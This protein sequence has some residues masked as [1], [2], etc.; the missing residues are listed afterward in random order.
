[1]RLHT[2]FDPIGQAV[3]MFTGY[4]QT[5]KQSI[6]IKMEKLPTPLPSRNVRKFYH[7]FSKADCEDK[8]W[9]RRLGINSFGLRIVFSKIDLEDADEDKEARN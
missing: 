9:R 8:M 2:K 5:D 7:V 4:K 1:M 6:Y 3:L